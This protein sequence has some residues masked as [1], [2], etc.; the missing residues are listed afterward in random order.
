[1]MNQTLIKLSEILCR[2]LNKSLKRVSTKERNALVRNAA[3]TAIA[4]NRP[5]HYFLDSECQ[6]ISQN[7]YKTEASYKGVSAYEKEVFVVLK[8]N[9]G[10]TLR[11]SVNFRDKVDPRKAY[12][13]IDS[14][15]MGEMEV[16]K[17]LRTSIGIIDLNGILKIAKY[18]ENDTLAE[19]TFNL[20]SAIAF[21]KE[22]RLREE[23]AEKFFEASTPARETELQS[24]TPNQDSERRNTMIKEHKTE[25]VVS[26]FK[27]L[28]EDALKLAAGQ[29]GLATVRAFILNAVPRKMGFLA[30]LTGKKAAAHKFLNS[31]LGGFIITASVHTFFTIL[32]PNN[33]RLLAVTRVA[34][35]AAMVELTMK[36][37]YQA[38]ADSLAAQLVNN[39]KVANF[40]S[41][42]CDN[43]DKNEKQV[44]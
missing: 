44:G 23:S 36:V 13:V 1:M 16:D 33:K 14:G 15:A 10:G 3:G 8:M 25:E 9:S 32:T 20:I 6:R 17:D 30:K 27:K 43:T 22:V 7:I 24:T 31:P 35:N 39:E 28:G 5:V 21:M 34:L 2:E 42:G 11:T 4:Q 12:I 40:L 19:A 37:P 41:Q 26:E 18:Y 29:A 38:M